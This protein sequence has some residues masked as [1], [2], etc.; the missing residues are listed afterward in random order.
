MVSFLGNEI[1]DGR[2]AYLLE[3]EPKETEGD[4]QDYIFDRMR[5][6]VDNEK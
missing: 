4:D 5:V 1:I 2:K 3:A 6:W